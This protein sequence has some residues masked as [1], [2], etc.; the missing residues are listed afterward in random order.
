M[1]TI[2]RAITQERIPELSL[3]IKIGQESAALTEIAPRLLSSQT[4]KEVQASTVL[5]KK[6]SENLAS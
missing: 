2:Q 5:V 6:S 3:A 1:N 4:K